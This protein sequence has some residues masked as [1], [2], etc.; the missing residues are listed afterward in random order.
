[1]NNISRG[2][3]DIFIT[4]ITTITI[5][6]GFVVTFSYFATTTAGGVGSAI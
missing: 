6:S 2:V 1:M 4:F 5:G 3:L